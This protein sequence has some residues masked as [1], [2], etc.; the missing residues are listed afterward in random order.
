MRPRTKQEAVMNQM[1]VRR[2]II[3]EASAPR[4]ESEPSVKRLRGFSRLAHDWE[5]EGEDVHLGSEAITMYAV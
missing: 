1:N 3:R 4:S 5:Y 2:G